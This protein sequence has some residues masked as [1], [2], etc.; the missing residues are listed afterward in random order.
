M[1]ELQLKKLRKTKKITQVELAERAD[2]DQGAISRMED[3]QCRSIGLNVLARL[4]KFLDCKPED[5]LV[6]VNENTLN[7]QRLINKRKKRDMRFVDFYK[8][9]C[10]HWI[11][12]ITNMLNGWV[13]IGQTGKHNPFIR[14]NEHLGQLDRNK[15]TNPRMQKDYTNTPESIREFVWTFELI[16]AVDPSKPELKMVNDIMV[17]PPGTLK[18]L[19]HYWMKYHRAE[20]L[21]LYNM[22]YNKVRRHP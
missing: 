2:I 6:L 17:E 12:R 18:N 10:S 20:G 4:C 3:G 1:I 8:E 7:S 22:A 14:W 9:P 5:L 19:E 16:D 15:H 11:Y 21:T 13:Y